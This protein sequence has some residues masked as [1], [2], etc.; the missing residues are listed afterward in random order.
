MLYKGAA[1]RYECG[2]S[3]NRLS[4]NCKRVLAESLRRH[5]VEPCVRG[6]RIRD[7]LL[8]PGGARAS[9]DECLNQWASMERTV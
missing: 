2:A 4:T 3:G 7:R 6:A 5:I 9:S 1:T 8:E